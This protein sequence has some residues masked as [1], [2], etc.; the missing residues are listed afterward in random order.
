MIPPFNN[1]IPWRNRL[2]PVNCLADRQS[3]SAPYRRRAKPFTDL[4]HAHI[5]VNPLGGIFKKIELL[6]PAN[7]MAKPDTN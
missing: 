7:E 5:Q 1:Q 4:I 3:R 6:G 2:H